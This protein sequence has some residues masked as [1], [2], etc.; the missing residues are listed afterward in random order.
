MQ[1]VLE[2][3]EVPLYHLLTDALLSTPQ[4]ESIL[5]KA[6]T[7]PD[8]PVIPFFGSFMREIRKIMKETP[9]NIVLTDQD[10]KVLSEVS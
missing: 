2:N 3:E 7:M 1:A 6:L 5:Q 8:C 9:S 4:Y 10:G